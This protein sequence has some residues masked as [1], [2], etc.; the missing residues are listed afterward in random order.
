MLCPTFFGNR[1]TFLVLCIIAL[2]IGVGDFHILFNGRHIEHDEFDI[3]M[4]G[5]GELRFMRLVESGE[6]ILRD[7]DLAAIG[8]RIEYPTLHFPF[9]FEKIPD[10]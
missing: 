7:L 2:E 5:N 9:L 3:G 6:F 1:E 4:F 8:R 10:P